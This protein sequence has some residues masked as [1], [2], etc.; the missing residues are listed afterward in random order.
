MH[1]VINLRDRD[2]QNFCCLA[3]GEKATGGECIHGAS[4]FLGGK[5]WEE[6]GQGVDNSSSGS[7][8]PRDDGVLAC[9]VRVWKGNMMRPAIDVRLVVGLG[10]VVVSIV[11]VYTLIVAVDRTTAV[12]VAAESLPA[13]Q[14]L[15]VSD[16]D[17]V[18][19]RLSEASSLYVA[20]QELPLNSVTMRSLRAGELVPR[21]AVGKARDITTTTLVLSLT[22]DLPAEAMAGE[23]VDIW[24]APQLG[25][26]GFG[27]P[28][29]LVSGALIARIQERSGIGSAALGVSVEVVIP[30]SKIALVLQAQANGDAISLVPAVGAGS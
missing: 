6:L 22:S 12:Y 23:T 1:E 30:R 9:I 11:G 24:S 29:I 21:S 4:L 7:G 18:H 10:L 20:A 16:L 25:Q 5:Q 8:S 28:S 3:N 15:T 19:V 26:S 17:V 13:G 2:R 14:T 27:A